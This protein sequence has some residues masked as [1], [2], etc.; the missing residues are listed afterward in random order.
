MGQR[1]LAIRPDRALRWRQLK[2]GIA[3][4]RRRVPAIAS[5]AS[6]DAKVRDGDLSRWEPIFKLPNRF[7][8]SH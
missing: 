8:R 3:A 4:F 7:G 5:P 2:R 1:P 6:E